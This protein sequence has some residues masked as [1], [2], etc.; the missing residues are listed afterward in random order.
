L[1]DT[2]A[3]SGSKVRIVGDCLNER[4]TVWDD[5]CKP[6]RNGLAG[7]AQRIEIHSPLSLVILVLG[8]ELRCSFFRQM[9]VSILGSTRPGPDRVH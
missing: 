2:L 7:L 8:R 4:R 3:A 9:R 1:E 5:P 6:G